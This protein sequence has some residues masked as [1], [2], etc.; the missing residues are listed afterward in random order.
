MW[1]D[2]DF[3]RLSVFAQWL[4]MALLSH[5]TLSYTGVADWRPGRIAAF[6][7]SA[8]VA[9]V[10]EAADELMA[11]RFI[12]TDDVTEEVLVRSFVKHDGLLKQPKL[13]VSMCNAFAAVASTPLREVIA[14]EVQ[15]L[16]QSEPALKAW[17]VSQMQT[18]LR[19]DAA[20]IDQHLPSRLGERLP[21][22][23][24]LDL[25]ETEGLGLGL[26]TSTATS[27][28][29]HQLE[30]GGLAPRHCK[31][32]SHWDHNEKCGACMKDRQAHEAEKKQLEADARRAARR[33]PQF[34]PHGL[35]RY[36]ACE[37]CGDSWPGK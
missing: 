27:T 11:G 21:Q 31:K 18:V 12:L 30:I 5:P 35:P 25:P 19:A 6:S 20:P 9:D 1:A 28:A 37:R 36:E 4:Y 16:R 14:Y 2:G 7:E 10:V 32:H 24:P 15:K 17:E 8:E 13:T 23:L 34:C 3:R 29:T 26:P 33:Q 22:G